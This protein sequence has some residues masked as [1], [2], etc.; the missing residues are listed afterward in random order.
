MYITSVVALRLCWKL[1][2]ESQGLGLMDFTQRPQRL[3]FL[4]S[5]RSF[6]LK[7]LF[8]LKVILGLEFRP[9]VSKNRSAKP[10]GQFLIQIHRLFFFNRLFCSHSVQVAMG[11]LAFNIIRSPDSVKFM[12]TIL[13]PKYKT[14]RELKNLELEYFRFEIQFSFKLHFCTLTC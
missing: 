12:R 3:L 8:T 9:W 13:F 4:T 7:L 14:P 1:H 2:Q 11:P 10:A 6:E 5:I